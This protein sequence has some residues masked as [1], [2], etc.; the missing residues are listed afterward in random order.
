MKKRRGEVETRGRGERERQKLHMSL[1]PRRPFYASPRHSFTFALLLLFALGAQ[2]QAQSASAGQAA[3]VEGVVVDQTGAAVADAQVSVSDGSRLIA[4]TRTDAEGKFAFDTTATAR[5]C[6]LAIKAAGFAVAE[7]KCGDKAASNPLRIVL[8]PAPVSEEMT[9]TGLRTETRLGETAA[10]VVLLSSDELRRTG[11]LTLDDALRQ[12]PGFTLFRRSSSRTANP[13]TQGVSLRGVG[14]SGS[15]RAVVLEDG[16]PLNDPF[17]GWVNWAR[18][19]R[20]SVSRV[21]ILRGGFSGLYGSGA[22]GGA[23]NILTRK[24]EPPAISFEVSF[25]NETT[26]DGSVFISTREG[27]WGASF[28]AESFYTEGYRIVREIERGPVDTDAAS[29]HAVHE[30]T[31]ER[32]L[33]KNARAFIRASYFGESRKNGTPAQ[34]N[35]THIREFRAGLDEQSSSAGSLTLRIYGGSQ[36]YDQTFSAVAADRRS[37]SLTR[38]QRV[39]AQFIGST[40]QWSRV[41]AKNH[42]LVA[43]LDAREVRGASDETVFAQNL[44]SSL[45]GAGGRERDVGLFAQDIF[46]VTPRFFI[47]GGARFD[48]WRNYAAF[49]AT[50]SLRQINAPTSINKFADRA[51]SA[52]SPQL[53]M[54]FKPAEKI[55]LNA[56]VYRSFRAPTLNELYR[57]FRVGDTLTLANENLRAERLTGGET[58]MSIATFERRLNVRGNLFWSEITRPIANATLTTTP[59]LITRQRQNLGRTRSR[60]LELEAEARFN[61]HWSLTSGYLFADAR[62]LKFP[63]N[64]A[65]EGLLIPQVARHQFT[66]QANYTNSHHFN[67][68]LQCRAVGSQFDDDQNRFRLAPYF[69]LDATA[70]RRL[71]HLVEIFVAAENI[72][73]NRYEIGRTPVT[74][75][76]PPLLVRIGL[77]ARFGLQ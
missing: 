48:H 11:A 68:S 32:E 36:V 65:L 25:G 8:A 35:R 2:A 66:F 7:R 47:A 60:G 10:S 53:S 57:S 3:Q 15:S 28:A 27:R 71:R 75:V 76:G 22:M 23:V 13:T 30:F 17:G 56:S 70:S 16:V 54:L 59:A 40:F 63:A 46:R 45:V 12:V 37:E 39:P 58:G 64:I 62:V 33:R 41:V 4:E 18:V 73:N 77:R 5:S 74:T 29:R 43:G 72:L 19:P 69:T 55:S 67:F 51:E 9:V 50:R 42:T 1:S 34:I 21:E 44:L 24:I 38:V 49:S 20:D 31:L 52:I 6:R 61:N 14:A 26:P